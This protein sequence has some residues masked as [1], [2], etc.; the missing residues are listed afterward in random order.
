MKI[1]LKKVWKALKWAWENHDKIDD[2]IEHGKEIIEAV[3]KKKEDENKE[4]TN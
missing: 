4:R 2:V 1:N 3:K